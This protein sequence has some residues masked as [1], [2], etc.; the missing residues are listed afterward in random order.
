MKY[1]IN[2]F[3]IDITVSGRWKQKRAWAEV[4]AAWDLYDSMSLEHFNALITV[5]NLKAE[6][7][8]R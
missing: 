3:H 8:R 4:K 5:T 6:H 1:M 7:K 2:K